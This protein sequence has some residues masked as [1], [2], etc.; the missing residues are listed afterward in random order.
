M[1]QNDL[2]NKFNEI[3][4]TVNGIIINRKNLAN[5]AQSEVNNVINNNIQQS[6]FENGNIKND[7]E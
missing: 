4:K 7:Y 3:N 2:N 1:S 6:Y 5:I